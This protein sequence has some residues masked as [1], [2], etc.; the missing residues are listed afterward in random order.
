MSCLNTKDSQYVDM[1]LASKGQPQDAA[2]LG[3]GGPHAAP[4]AAPAKRGGGGGHCNLGAILGGLGL[5][6]GVVS[7]ILSIYAASV[8]RRVSA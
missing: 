4:H 3:A 1:E 8:A 2:M 7:L 6:L 5:L